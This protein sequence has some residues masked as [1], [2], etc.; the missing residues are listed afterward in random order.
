MVEYGLTWQFVKTQLDYS[1]VFVVSMLEPNF[2]AV[3][4][5]I[6]L[7]LSAR[8]SLLLCLPFVVH[9]GEHQVSILD[10]IE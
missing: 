8:V 5:L 3:L 4:S 7:S 9:T 10:E 6:N 2:F 1:L